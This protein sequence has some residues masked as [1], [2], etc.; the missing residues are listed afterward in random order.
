[1]THPTSEPASNHVERSGASVGSHHPKPADT[2]AQR[3]LALLRMIYGYRVSA[4]LHVLE[5]LGIADALGEGARPHQ[6]LAAEVGA[7]APTLLRL[8]R[9]AAAQGLMAE[10]APSCFELTSLGALLRSDVAGSVRGAASFAADSR[11]LRTWG[12]LLS[13]ARS[14]EPTFDHVWGISG[15]EYFAQN[16]EIGAAFNAAMARGTR[17]S[18]PGILAACDF[19]RFRT[20]VDVGGGNGTLL[21]A[22]LAAAPEARGVLQDTVATSEDARATLESAGIAERVRLAA[23]DFFESVVAGGDCYVLKHVL[24]DFS[25]AECSAILRNIRAVL[26]D[27]GRVVIIESVLPDTV[28][29]SDVSWMVVMADLNMLVNTTGRER[30]ERGYRELLEVSGFELLGVRPAATPWPVSVIEAWPS[31]E[32]V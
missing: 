8:L 11:A 32:R 28:D 27:D 5:R 25:D 30:T 26:P 24:H 18:A 4:L 10:V 16:P 3:R 9:G 23:T 14:G 20:V 1:M 7:D 13:T 19:T 21:G 22:I 17:L 31:R 29:A 15:F 12:E 2:L 6:E